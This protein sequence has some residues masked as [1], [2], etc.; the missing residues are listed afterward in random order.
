MASYTKLLQVSKDTYHELLLRDEQ[1]LF[2]K[3]G[4]HMHPKY[5]N[6][7]DCIILDAM[8]YIPKSKMGLGILENLVLGCR[9]HH[10]L[11]DNGGKGYRD[12]MLKLTEKHLKSLYPNWKREELVYRKWCS[13]EI[14]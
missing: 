4:Y 5:P 14:K 13:Y 12:E 2:C 1:C 8:H 9:Y 11:L 10:H 7:M 6:T 3:I